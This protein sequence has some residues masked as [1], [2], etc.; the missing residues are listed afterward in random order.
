MP[1]SFNTNVLSAQ[2]TGSPNLMNTTLSSNGVVT[3]WLSAN[4]VGLA[5]NAEPTLNV[6]VANHSIDNSVFVINTI[7]HNKQMALVKNNNSYTVFTHNSGYAVT[8][9]SAKNSAFDVITADGIR[10]RVLGYR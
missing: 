8:P 1:Y 9:L 6:Q 3:L 5:F 10:K 2:K 7:Y 4:D